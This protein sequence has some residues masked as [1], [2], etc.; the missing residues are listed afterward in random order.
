[1]ILWGFFDIAGME[2]WA[3]LAQ[4]HWKCYHTRLDAPLLQWKPG[5][6][7]G[8]SFRTYTREEIA[9]AV[10]MVNRELLKSPSRW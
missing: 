7:S 8:R 10:S 2:V 4:Y 3:K 6:F 9:Q 5:W 1:M